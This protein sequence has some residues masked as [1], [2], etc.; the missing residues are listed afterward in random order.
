[1]VAAGLLGLLVGSFTN[2]LI[3][4][5][6]RRESVSFPPSRCPRCGGRLGARDLVPVLSWL[7]LRGRCRQCAAP[8][9]PRYPTVELLSGAGF[10]LVALAYPPAL[11]GASTW[12]LLPLVTVLIAAAATDLDTFTIPDELSLGG[13]ALGLAAA[14]VHGLLGSGVDL[15][16]AA[17][18][19]SPLPLPGLPGALLGAAVG[20]GVL[21]TVGLYGSWVLRRGSERRHPEYPLG[22]P[23]IALALLVG[24][25]F[26]PLWALAAV[27][28]SVFANVIARRPLPVPDALTLGGTLLTLALAPTLGRDLLAM[29]QGAAAGAGAA[30]LIAGLYWAVYWARRG[31]E[32][33]ESEPEAGESDSDPVAVGDA[34]PVAMGFGDIKL[35]G[36]IGA[37]LG[38]SGALLA[39]GVAVFAGALIG[40]AQLALT[41]QSRMKF[42]P[43]L[44]LGGLVALLWGGALL[45]WWQGYLGML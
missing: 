3:H 12:L 37:F 40:A 41:R 4:R 14:L 20:A 30:A 38:A 2:V 32:D 28:L 5:L 42:G 39:L 34:D 1:M 6:P 16:P 15:A 36:A 43:A 8:I 13:L 9:S 24:A 45:G 21:A 35:A 27:A 26:G 19:L 10:A 18:G 22:Y 44:S 25:W 17:L 7:A 31:G 23:Q 11:W 29:L 33:A